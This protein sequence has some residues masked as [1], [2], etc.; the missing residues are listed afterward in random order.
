M[1]AHF[2]K[3]D[4]FEPLRSADAEPNVKSMPANVPSQSIVE[5]SENMRAKIYGLFS[6]LGN[7]KKQKETNLMTLFR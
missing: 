3:P 4:T 6:R 7:L 2:F 1:K 5:I